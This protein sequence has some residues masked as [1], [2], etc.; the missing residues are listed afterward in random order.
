MKKKIKTHRKEQQE[1]NA[2][3]GEMPPMVYHV[4]SRWIITAQGISAS[5]QITVVPLSIDARDVTILNGARPVA[6]R[7]KSGQTQNQ[8]EI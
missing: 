1:V 7:P 4:L 3:A 5:K 2:H 8:R 6:T